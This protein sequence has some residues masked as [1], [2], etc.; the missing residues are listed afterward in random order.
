MYYVIFFFFFSSRRRHTRCALVTGVQKCALPIWRLAVWT[1]SGSGMS[2]GAPE[3]VPAARETDPLC[4]TAIARGAAVRSAF[5][6]ARD[7]ETVATAAPG[8]DRLERA[9]GVE[10][11]AQAADEDFEHVGIAVRSE[12][13]TSELQSLMRISYAV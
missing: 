2:S 7:G 11:L 10:L 13:H 9:L 1:C 8:F 4:P 3:P 6:A 12:E 5:V